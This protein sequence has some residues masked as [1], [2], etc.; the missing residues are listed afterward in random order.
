M[1]KIR[2]IYTFQH[3]ELCSPVFSV[4]SIRRGDLAWRS[5]VTL[6]M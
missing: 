5:K 6:V 1:S 4:W 2:C 3:D